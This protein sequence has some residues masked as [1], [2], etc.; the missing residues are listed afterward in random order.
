[1]EVADNALSH[2]INAINQRKVMVNAQVKAT[3]S[4]LE[5]SSNVIYTVILSFTVKTSYATLVQW[6]FLYM[7]LLP[8]AFLMNTSHN[9]NRIV[10]YG[11]INV[12]KNLI[13]KITNSVSHDTSNDN[14]NTGVYNISGK[15][16]HRENPLTK[17]MIGNS[18]QQH[19]LPCVNADNVVPF[20]EP[21]S[22][23]GTSIPM[24]LGIQK[25][26]QASKLHGEIL[27]RD[28]LIRSMRE[29]IDD[30]I[31]YLEFFKDFVQFEEHCKGGKDI[32]AFKGNSTMMKYYSAT[33]NKTKNP[34]FNRKLK[35]F[36]SNDFKTGSKCKDI[37]LK[38]V[39]TMIPDVN[40][41]SEANQIET[42]QNRIL[43]LECLMLS[44]E[45]KS[46]HDAFTEQ[47]IN[48]EE[49]VI[50]RR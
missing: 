43:L 26:R 17:E 4:L 21:S 34:N 25:R 27:I 40:I 36:G 38:S 9:K 28:R 24:V 42:K 50:N 19:D 13:T 48:L 8:Y 16:Q 30:E 14:E 6:I 46:T 18:S 41:C 7:I 1:M 37:S 44:S 45:Q 33:K 10:E 35:M 22:S 15:L 12:F 20:I 39:D 49:G 3:I 23:K 11:W 47:L 32:S 31:E 5:L 2:D 29:H